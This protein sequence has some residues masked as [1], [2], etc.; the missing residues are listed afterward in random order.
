[1]V[2]CFAAG[3]DGADRDANGVVDSKSIGSHAAAKNC[4]TVG[5]TE[6]RR[7]DL[8]WNP[9]PWR[10]TAK[11]F[12]YGEYFTQ[13]YPRPPISTD[14]M[15]NNS[16]GMAAFSSRG[17]TRE[18]RFKPDVVAPGSSIL[19]T[20]SRRITPPTH[21]GI[22]SDPVL[23]FD[24]GTSMATPLVA[25]CCAVLRQTL[26][27]N[28]VDQPS[29]ALIKALLIN[30][31]V[32]IIG[33]YNPTE[34]K[35]I[36]NGDEGWGRVDLAGSV[37]IPGEQST[38]GCGDGN[39]LDDDE[40]IE[41]KITIP[42]KEVTDDHREPI[43]LKVTLVYSDFPGIELQNDLNLIVIG[44]RRSERHGNMGT[45]NYPIG[46]LE[47]FDGLNNVEQVIWEGIPSGETTIKVRASRITAFAQPFAYAWRI[48]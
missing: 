12:T 26:V 34:A 9:P 22:S 39:P 17:P 13:S 25:G 45:R 7:P 41:V 24:T 40:E 18:Q 43:R 47:G 48:Y 6:S 27:Q 20:A 35:A 32:D 30:G 38:A 37:I 46:S 19:S 28:G 2:I 1:M 29:A 16:E 23:M 3:N 15:A 8:K 11:S 36:P 10:P 33:Q 21:Y 4:I 42:E 44:S 31:A 14:H 5:A